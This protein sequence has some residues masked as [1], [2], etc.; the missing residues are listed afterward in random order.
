MINLNFMVIYSLLHHFL[1]I[2]FLVFLNGRSIAK[3]HCEILVISSGKIRWIAKED[4]VIPSN[5]IEAGKTQNGESVYI[6]RIKYSNDVI[7]GGIRRSRQQLG[8]IHKGKI[9]TFSQYEILVDNT[10]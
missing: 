6:G 8:G 9:V 2:F 3:D 10:F 5:A 4:G 1:V 7:V